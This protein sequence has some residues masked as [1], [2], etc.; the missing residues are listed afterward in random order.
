MIFRLQYVCKLIVAQWR[1]MTESSMHQV[2]ACSLAAAPSRYLNFDMLLVR[3]RGIYANKFY[4]GI[5]RPLTSSSS[6]LLTTWVQTNIKV[7][8][9]THNTHKTW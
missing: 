4:K 5:R 2:M 3:S 9:H 7:N 8:L 1:H 6:I